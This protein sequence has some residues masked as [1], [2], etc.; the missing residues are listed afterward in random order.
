MYHLVLRTFRFLPD[1]DFE[2]LQQLDLHSSAVKEASVL[3]KHCFGHQNFEDRSF[4]FHRLLHWDQ[5]TRKDA[6]LLV[7]DP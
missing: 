2:A 4:S 3:P 7:G 6:I 5:M 1:L